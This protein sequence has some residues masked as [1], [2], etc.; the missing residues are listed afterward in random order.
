MLLG[1]VT[2]WSPVAVPGV[3]SLVNL[4]TRLVPALDEGSLV[5]AGFVTAGALGDVESALS[6]TLPDADIT[7]ADL[8][9]LFTLRYVFDGFRSV[10]V[11]GWNWEKTSFP[12]QEVL[13]LEGGID[14]D[15]GPDGVFSAVLV[16][17][18]P[19]WQIVSLHLDR[20]EC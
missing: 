14:Y 15:E 1:A 10:E 13:E 17:E 3:Q 11:Q 12:R 16:K 18:G 9:E 7:R 2:P 6:L 19:D 20:P 4:S 5:V 8:V